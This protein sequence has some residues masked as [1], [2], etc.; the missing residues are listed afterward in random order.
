M[1]G[2]FGTRMEGGTCQCKNMQKQSTKQSKKHIKIC[3]NTVNESRTLE[4]LQEYRCMSW[5]VAN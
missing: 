4:K 5:Q 3:K 1:Y 2:V